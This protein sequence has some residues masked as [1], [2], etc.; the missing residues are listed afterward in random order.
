VRHGVRVA[1]SSENRL[2][3]IY[4][5]MGGL[6]IGAC[7]VPIYATVPEKD[8]A[9]VVNDC[10]AIVVIV[11]D[12]FQLEKIQS[13]D[14]AD[15]YLKNIIVIDPSGCDVDGDKVL[16]FQDLIARG[17]KKHQ[18]DP[19]LFERLSNA[20]TPDDPQPF[21]TLPGVRG[22]QKVPC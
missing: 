10:E 4:A 21:N 22:C 20:V 6:G 12:N 13:A 3:W 1:I 7:V 15:L 18:T 5:D 11:E 9:Y 17:E 2:E 19:E 16:C 14:S 8:V